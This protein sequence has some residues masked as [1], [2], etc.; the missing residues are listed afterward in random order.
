MA[1][2]TLFV[3]SMLM[4]HVDSWHLV[5]EDFRI[6]LVVVWCGKFPP[7]IT[8]TFHSLSHSASF[9]NMIV[10]TDDQQDIQRVPSNVHLRPLNIDHVIEKLVASRS[11][12]FY[13]FI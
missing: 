11:F 13:D 6:A 5:N 8:Y 4:V 9:L 1:H 3:M 7:W 12:S 2:L 10:Y